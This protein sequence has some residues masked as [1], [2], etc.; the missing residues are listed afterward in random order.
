MC[1]L[2]QHSSE[3]NL[4][5]IE[6]ICE[7][8]LNSNCSLNN[9]YQAKRQI[10]QTQKGSIELCRTVTLYDRTPTFYNWNYSH[11][12]NIALNSILNRFQLEFW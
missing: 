9:S 6:P 10:E 8:V 1:C 12:S 3:I 2:F 7:V 11:E 4:N 5:F